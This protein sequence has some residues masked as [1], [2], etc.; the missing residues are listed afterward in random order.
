MYVA[1]SDISE[2][3]NNRRGAAVLEGTCYYTCNMAYIIL[4]DV[5]WLSL[6]GWITGRK[7]GFKL[8]LLLAT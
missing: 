8:K 5:Q 2:V 4:N 7:L 1:G 6:I 3:E